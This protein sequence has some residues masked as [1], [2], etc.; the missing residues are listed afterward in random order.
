MMC[1]GYQIR[2]RHRIGPPMTHMLRDLEPSLD[3]DMTIL[4]V[5]TSDQPALQ[6]ALRRLG[7]LGL[8]IVSVERIERAR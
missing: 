4:R 8:E 3:D 1:S 7:D 2:V 6:G 5:R